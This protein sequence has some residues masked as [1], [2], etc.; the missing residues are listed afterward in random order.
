MLVSTDIGARKEAGET[1]FGYST[2][3]P[4]TNVQEAIEYVRSLIPVAP[5]S[6]NLGS[7]DNAIVRTDGTGGA[8]AQGSLVTIDD[9]GIMNGA[10]AVGVNA[11][12][13][14]TNRLSV[15]STA[16]LFNHAGAGTQLKANKNA[17][18]DTVSHLFQT[19][20]SSRAEF[21]LIG[22]NDFTLK[23]SSNGSAFTTALI[24]ANTDGALRVGVNLRPTANDG[25]ALGLSGTAWADLFLASGAVINFAAGDVTITHSTDTLA[26]AGA[27]TA[28]TF[29]GGPVRPSANDGAALGVSG[30]AWSDLFLAS[31][32]VINFNAGDVTLTHSTD[33]LSMV[34]GT[35]SV[36]MNGTTPLTL[37]HSSAGNNAGMMRYFSRPTTPGS[38]D[39]SYI[40]F[41]QWNSAS[42]DT[43]TGTIETSFTT[44]TAGNETSR[45]ALGTRSNGS[46]S[47]RVALTSSGLTPVAN[48]QLPLGT[49]TLSWGDLFLASGGVINW[50]NGNYTLTHSAGLLTA[51]GALS[52]GTGN[53]F[54]CGTIELGA[55]SDTTISRSA[56]GVI[57]VEGVPL[58]AGIPQ[59]SQST[60]YTT[61]LADAQKHILHPTADN[62]ARTF[63]IAANASVAYPI[64]TCITFVNQ[65]NTVTIAINSDTLT[66]AGSGATGSRTLAANGIATALKITS[67]IWII[68][69]TGLT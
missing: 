56:A 22:D 34:G 42:A 18:G 10:T 64:G 1:A 60:A 6:G 40:E 16:V 52:I 37:T 11:T 31:G 36:S 21:G 69:G 29:N 15:N 9:V 12:A 62:N 27:A 68:S 26:F 14:A 55:A 47:F 41:N 39:A 66:L 17:S 5:V 63:T 46:F 7:T 2:A 24:A 58:F 51:N 28:Y 53:A 13:D 35:L 32:G 49:G 57:A 23:V 19:A 38:T 54:T 3:I 50:N 25:A 45:I 44:N 33:T 20:F 48:D 67:T 59:N 8:L 65:I 43:N 4:R 30:T 61:V